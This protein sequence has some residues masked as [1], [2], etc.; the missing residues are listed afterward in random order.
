MCNSCLFIF[1]IIYHNKLPG[2]VAIIVTYSQYWVTTSF[3][4]ELLTIPTLLKNTREIGQAIMYHWIALI[5]IRCYEA[6][7]NFLSCTIFHLIWKNIQIKKSF[8]CITQA[9][10]DTHYTLIESIDNAR[11]STSSRWLATT[12]SASTTTRKSRDVDLI[13]NFTF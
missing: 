6:D 4:L 12:S 11:K 5:P 10:Y 2:R 3:Q 13:I 7:S 1:L 8:V 9:K